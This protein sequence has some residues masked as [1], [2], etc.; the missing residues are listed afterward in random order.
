MIGKLTTG[1]LNFRT[2]WIKPFIAPLISIA[3]AL[4]ILGPHLFDLSVPIEG[5]VRAHIFKIDTLSA[6]L[7][8]GSWPLWNTYWYHGFP[9][10]QYY[11]PGFYLLGAGLTFVT[12]QAVIAYKLLLFLALV[13]NGLAAYYFARRFLKITP[14]LALLCLVAYQSATPLLMNYLYGTGPNLLS[15]SICVFCLTI[16]F[17]N[18]L[19]GRLHGLG[20]KLVPGLL[21]G[22]TALIHPYPAIFA[23]L[24][25]IVFHLVLVLR[26]ESPPDKVRPQLL[27][28]I[29]VFG[30]GAL[31]SAHYW[32]PALLTR[33]YVSPIYTFTADAWRG[34][35]PYLIMLSLLALILGLITRLRITRDIKVDLLIALLVLAAALGFGLSR[36]LPF[37]ELLHEFRFATIAAPF[38]ATSLVAFSL[39]SMPVTIN[40][41]RLGIAVA[42][43]CLVLITSVFP[44]ISTYNSANLDR[45]FA[46]TQNYRQPEYTQLIQS[47][48]PSRLIVPSSKGYLCEGDSPVTFA[49]R[50]NVATVNGGYNQGDPKFFRH[51]VYL[52][53]EERWLEYPFIRENLMRASAA[54]YLFI[55]CPEPP[56]ANMTGMTLVAENSYGQLWELD[57]DVYRAASVS[58]VL[59]DVAEPER[60]TEFFN[61]LI[62]GGYRMVFANIGEVTDDI[63]GEFRYVMLDDESK[64]PEYSGQTVFLLNDS[65][66]GGD[67]ISEDGE[68]INLNLPYLTYTSRFFYRGD[69]GD[70]SAWGR[71]EVDLSSQLDDEAFNAIQQIGGEMDEYLQELNYE[72]VGYEYSDIETELNNGPGFT[73]AKDSYFPYWNTTRGEI[74]P[75]TQ[76]FILIYATDGETRLTYEK[77]AVG[78]TTTIVTISSIVAAVILLVVEALRRRKYRSRAAG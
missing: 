2:P 14:A 44:F 49:W 62:P 60:V 53:W 9:A 55:R 25:I 21:L 13:T 23:V 78:T 67:F 22:I 50:D 76:G 3:I 65:D 17:S 77:P 20:P 72:P 33:D 37:G 6:Y 11:P 68:I 38:F 64:I 70:I 74:M 10:F 24:A 34:G 36:Y 30:I 28:L 5:D 8:H 4:A 26:R 63:K 7:S 41:R 57:G 73:L 31:V 46:Y 16:Y 61:I 43:I 18:I 59:L 45:L 19:E 15:W 48:E 42:G 66:R 39:G 1:A 69:R 71:F 75:T 35:I 54:G 58:P 51:T 47:A 56:P 12:G 29:S 27:N 52:E 32:L 40:R